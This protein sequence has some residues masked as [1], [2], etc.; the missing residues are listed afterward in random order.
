MLRQGM[1]AVLVG[2]ALGLA[3]AYALARWIASLL[4][5]TSSTDPMVFGVAAL[6]M[7]GVALVAS[8]F[9]ARNAS[10]VDPARVLKSG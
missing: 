4:Y 3:L 6:V 9:P 2:I 1:F 5:G 8:Y 10:T 7:L